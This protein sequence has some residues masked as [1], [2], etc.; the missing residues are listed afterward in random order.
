MDNLEQMF[1]EADD[2]CQRFI[3]A[4]QQEL[5]ENEDKCRNKPGQLS[6]SEVI[7]L[8]ILFHHEN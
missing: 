5:L 7:T 4:W 2:C 1:C 6:E 3:P 8:L